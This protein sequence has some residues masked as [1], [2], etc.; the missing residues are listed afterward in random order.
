MKKL[1]VVGLT[2]GL[3]AGSLIG[4]AEAKKKKPKPKP[5]APVQVD[6]KFFMRQDNLDSCADAPHEFLSLTDG[7]DLSCSYTGGG[8]MYEAYHQANTASEGAVADNVPVA[9]SGE[10][11]WTTEDGTPFVLDGSKNITGEITVHA[12]DLE[13]NRPAA[14]QATIDV[15]L[16]GEVGGEVKELGTMT[17][18]YTATPD[19][20]DHLVKVDF[21]PEASLVGQ[22]FTSLTLTTRLRGAAFGATQI[23][24]DTPASFISV[25][26]IK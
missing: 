24:L 21:K 7:T 12:T 5:P 15:V 4:P 2:A 1:L 19:G 18:T 8:A 26:A 16:V 25:P 6:L 22:T 14:G 17:E 10:V 9:P 13:G 23:E 11:T 20:A 3:L